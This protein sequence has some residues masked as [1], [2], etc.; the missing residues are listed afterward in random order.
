MSHIPAL[1]ATL[2]RQLKSRGLTY[3]DVARHLDLSEA[4]VK[5]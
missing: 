3:A 1:I 2:K 5:C 4:S